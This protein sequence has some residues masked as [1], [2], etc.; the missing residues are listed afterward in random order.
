MYSRNYQLAPKKKKVR[1]A[2]ESKL[3]YERMLQG[4]D[5]SESK[6]HILV[7]RGKNSIDAMHNRHRI[8]IEMGKA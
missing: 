5:Q 8:D 7:T 4:N 2:W 3:L 6:Y 1:S